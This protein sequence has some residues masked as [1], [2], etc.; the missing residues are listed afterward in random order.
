MQQELE[1]R[2]PPA[3]VPAAL[4]S[5]GK[6]KAV[7][8]QGQI[9]STGEVFV[10]EGRV[11]SDPGNM[12]IA[13]LCKRTDLRSSKRLV[14][15]QV[16]SSTVLF[17]PPAIKA[18]FC[19]DIYNVFVPLAVPEPMCCP[20]LGQGSAMIACVVRGECK[21]CV[22]LQRCPESFVFL[23]VCQDCPQ[24]HLCVPR[25][26]CCKLLS[27]QKPGGLGWGRESEHSGSRRG[28]GVAAGMP[29]HRGETV[30]AEGWR[31]GPPA[32]ISPELKSQLHILCYE[33]QP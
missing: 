28:E 12:P 11:V 17:K 32:G 15:A 9:H 25:C 20:G 7:P 4:I 5:P 24:A 27:Q 33:T 22:Q 23:P 13:P 31:E 16:R 19:T 8:F 14:K 18:N 29:G 2:S 6:T 30:P 26:G 1:D 3:L 21:A 10:F